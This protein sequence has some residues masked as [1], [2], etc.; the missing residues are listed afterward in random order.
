MFPEGTA[1]DIVDEA[2]GREVH[3]C[4]AFAVDCHGFHYVARFWGGGERAFGGDVGRCVDCRGKLGGAE[5]VGK[6][7]VVV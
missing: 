4:F 1:F 7:R 5:Y 3:V 6:E 2:D